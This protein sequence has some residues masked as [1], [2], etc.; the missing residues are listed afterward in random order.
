VRS[1]RQ[2]SGP[3]GPGRP[4]IS[5]SGLPAWTVRRRS[6]LSGPGAV[7]AL[8]PTAAATGPGIVDSRPTAGTDSTVAGLV[9]VVAAT[10]SRL[11]IVPA[12]HLIAGLHQRASPAIH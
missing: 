11:V 5:S 3:L 9:G 7:S 1:G 12:S 6:C 10:A 2:P 4:V 8:P